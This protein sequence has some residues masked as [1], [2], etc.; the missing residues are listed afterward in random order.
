MN[1]SAY[2]PPASEMF[3]F[4]THVTSPNA[5]GINKDTSSKLP[6]DEVGIPLKQD[7][8]KDDAVTTI[9]PASE[10]HPTGVPFRTLG[11][12][13]EQYGHPWKNDPHQRRTSTLRVAM[14]YDIMERKD[15]AVRV[16]TPDYPPHVPSESIV[17]PEMKSVPKPV[18]KVLAYQYPSVIL[19]GLDTDIYESSKGMIVQPIGEGSYRVSGGSEPHVVLVASDGQT[20]KSFNVSCDCMFWQWQGPE[21]WAKVGDYLL[22]EL[23]GTASIPVEKDAKGSHRVCKHVAA[24]LRVL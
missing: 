18:N 9:G 22:G 2:T 8:N 14:L 19:K 17:V 24:V 15:P 21:H 11:K 12:P 10:T 16:F 7:K 4:Q 6:G 5:Q 13:G 1:K 20:P 3:Q 23:K